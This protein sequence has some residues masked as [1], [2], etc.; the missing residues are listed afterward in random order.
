MTPTIL[1]NYFTHFVSITYLDLSNLDL[2]KFFTHHQIEW[3]LYSYIKMIIFLKTLN[4]NT[5]SVIEPRLI[6]V[7]PNSEILHN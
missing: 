2:S 4:V 5:S 3:I 1:E 6:V 7:K